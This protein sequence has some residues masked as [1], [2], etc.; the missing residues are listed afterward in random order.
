MWRLKGPNLIRRSPYTQLLTRVR[1]AR[2][3]G[4]NFY[5]CT[6]SV[7]AA[8]KTR[9]LAARSCLVLDQGWEGITAPNALFWILPPPPP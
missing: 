1:S 7:T 4:D 8:A 5:L 6:W 2:A 9:L 3:N